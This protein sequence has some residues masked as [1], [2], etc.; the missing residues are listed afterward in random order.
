VAVLLR[1]SERHIRCLTLIQ[2][3]P[4]EEYRTND[5]CFIRIGKASNGATTYMSRV[6]L[7][8]QSMWFKAVAWNYFEGESFLLPKAHLIIMMLLVIILLVE[9]CSAYP[10]RLLHTRALTLNDLDPRTG[11]PRYLTANE[12]EFP[13]YITH[14]SKSQPDKAFGPQLNGAF[15]PNDIASIFSFDIP[16]SRANANCTLEFLLPTQEQLG[17]TYTYSGPGT[18]LFTGYQPGS[19]PGPQTTRNNQP[20]PGPFPPFPPIHME[21][22]NAYTIDVGPCFVG[23]GKCVAGVTSTPDTTFDYFQNQGGCPIG[24]CK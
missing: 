13:H 23:A 21:P 17:A 7:Q 9:A 3:K 15:T 11:C 18:F 16:A 19:C 12:F 22:G 20:Q 10:G 4:A 8:F 2:R 6:L 1:L 14:I 5:V 24:E